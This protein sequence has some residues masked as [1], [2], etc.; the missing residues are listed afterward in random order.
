MKDFYWDKVDKEFHL[1]A[2]GAFFAFVGM[3][4]VGAL[5]ALS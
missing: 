5:A 1:S 2:R 3:L 4:A